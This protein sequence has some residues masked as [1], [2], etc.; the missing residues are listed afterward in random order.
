M[1][2]A[3]T[4]R[5]AARSENGRVKQVSFRDLKLKIPAKCPGEILFDIGEDNVTGTLK[6]L[7]GSDQYT[8]VREAVKAEGLS[9]PDTVDALTTFLNDIF[10]K[11][12]GL[13]AGE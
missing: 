13:T 8:K 5:A 3:T 1:A 11:S 6:T 7:L 9:L 12:Y 4:K 2:T 10:E